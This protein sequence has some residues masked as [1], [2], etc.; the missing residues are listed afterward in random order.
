MI[1]AVLLNSTSTYLHLGCY[2]TSQGLKTLLNDLKINIIYEHEVNNYNFDNLNKILDSKLNTII[3]ING[4]GTFHD[5]QPYA[6]AL[7]D[8]VDR[9][10]IPFIILNSQFRNMSER[11]LCI[12]KRALAIQVR[13]QK[14]FEYLELHHF[15]N[16]HYCPD[17]L[18]Y[19]GITQDTN[20]NSGNIIFTD[21]HT[22]SGSEIINNLYSNDLSGKKWVNIHFKKNGNL[23]LYDSFKYNIAKNLLKFCNNIKMKNIVSESSLSDTIY[24]FISANAIVTGRYHAACLAIALEKPLIFSYSNTDKIKDLCSDFNWGCSY[25]EVD[26][27]EI[28]IQRQK[29]CIIDSKTLAKNQETLKVF[30]RRLLENLLIIIGKDYE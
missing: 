22:V 29:Q 16:H 5:D 15:G 10:S 2:L 21:S 24:S 19:S 11:Y 4:E 6:K 26:N 7:L 13:T 23:N 3:V 25:E 14:D 1:N 28:E 18:F 17:M 12:A 20:I 9:L 30:Y 8:F 27:L